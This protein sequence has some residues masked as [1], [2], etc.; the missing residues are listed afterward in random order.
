VR[1][2]GFEVQPAPTLLAGET[3]ISAETGVSSVAGAS[4]ASGG[5]V[6]VSEVAVLEGIASVVG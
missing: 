6:G 2:V 5:I 1:K 4:T 3:G